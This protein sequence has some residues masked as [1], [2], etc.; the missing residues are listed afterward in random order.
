[1]AFV[2]T[3]RNEPSLKSLLKYLTRKQTMDPSAAFKI[4]PIMPSGPAAF[5]F[6]RCLIAALTSSAVISASRISSKTSSVTSL[7]CCG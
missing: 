2:H 3:D 6:Y 7:S 1:M 5:L 4:S